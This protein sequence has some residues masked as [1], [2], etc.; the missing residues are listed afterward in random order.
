MRRVARRPT[1]VELPKE[2]PAADMSSEELAIRAQT[3]QQ[4]RD[5]LGRLRRRDREIV[6][7]CIEAQWTVREIGDRFA[8]PTREAARMAMVRAMRR[9]IVCIREQEKRR[10]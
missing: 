10:S 5:A 1:P 3:Y 4:Y 8:F 7:A 6:V 9:L 2:L